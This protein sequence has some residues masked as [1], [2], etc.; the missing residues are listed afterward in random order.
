MTFSDSSPHKSII[1]CAYNNFHLYIWFIGFENNALGIHVCYIQTN[2]IKV[3]IHI[4]SEEIAVMSE[5]EIVQ[6]YWYVFFK[7][8][9][10][11][12][13]YKEDIFQSFFLIYIKIIEI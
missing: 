11:Q 8:A 13:I 9:C 1:L 7:E 5:F 2:I 3:S 10:F 6:V 12:N 4:P